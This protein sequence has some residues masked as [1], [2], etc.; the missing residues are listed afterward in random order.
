[1][2]S[3]GTGTDSPISCLAHT[4]ARSSSSI[5]RQPEAFE[6]RPLLNQLDN[7]EQ[8]AA[9][10]SKD[11]SSLLGGD[12]WK[13]QTFGD[14]ENIKTRGKEQLRSLRR[15]VRISLDLPVNEI[16]TL[17]SEGDESEK[18]D[19]S[20]NKNRIKDHGKGN[21]NGNGKGKGKEKKNGRFNEK[22]VRSLL[23]AFDEREA[24]ARSRGANEIPRSLGR[25]DYDR[26]GEI[27][28]AEK[29]GDEDEGES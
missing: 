8:A 20:M 17:S 14:L 7:L 25:V 29:E 13:L 2:N 26:A 24:K 5:K 28:R 10:A 19:R 9:K 15:L 16:I 23:A 1:M 18:M 12:Q 21:G 4:L 6:P 11:I 27:L 22:V 3:K